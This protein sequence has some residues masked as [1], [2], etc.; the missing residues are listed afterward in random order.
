MIG[1][2]NCANPD[3]RRPIGVNNI[4]FYRLGVLPLPCRCGTVTIHF[5]GRDLPVE[6][7]M[8]R[9]D[10]WI[11]RAMKNPVKGDPEVA[12]R[13]KPTPAPVPYIALGPG[14]AEYFRRLREGREAG[15]KGGT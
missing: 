3:C 5:K 11:E 15:S 2:V 12:S 4:D 8:L 10:G 7:A 13:R 1:Y 14:A 9:A 6:A